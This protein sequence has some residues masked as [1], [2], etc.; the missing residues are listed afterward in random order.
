MRWGLASSPGNND[1]TRVNSLMLC[2]GRFRWDIRKNF[3]LER[4]VMY[5]NKLLREL[6]ESTS[7]EILKERVD[8]VLR[9]MI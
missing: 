9:D 8:V 5:W 4:V 6:V 7:P 2:W 3:Y 1:R